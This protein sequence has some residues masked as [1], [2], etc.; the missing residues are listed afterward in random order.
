M[1]IY[2]K[3][4]MLTRSFT[5]EVKV[6]NRDL[7]LRP[8]MFSRAGIVLG[9]ANTIVVPAITVFQQEG[10]NNRYVFINKKG[11]AKRVNVTIGERFDD[12]FEVISEKFLK[13]I[14]KKFRH[15]EVK[16]LYY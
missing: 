10:T 2:P 3:I 16:I 5:V 7:K 4:D 15:S 14:I 12:Q 1:N 9:S 6:P 11:V 13:E 8:G